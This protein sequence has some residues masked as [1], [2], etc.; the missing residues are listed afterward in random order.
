MDN[1][2]GLPTGSEDEA[3][4]STKPEKVS[5]PPAKTPKQ[6]KNITPSPRAKKVSPKSGQKLR[7]A[8]RLPTMNSEKSSKEMAHKCAVQAGKIKSVTP[9]KPALK[10][11]AKKKAAPKRKPSRVSQGKVSKG[12]PSKGKQGKPKASSS[13]KV[14]AETSKE[15]SPAARTKQ[16]L[17]KNLEKKRAAETE[18]PEQPPPARRVTAKSTDSSCAK[19]QP[20]EQQEDKKLARTMSSRVLQALQ[21][22]STRDQMEAA[23]KE[24][25]AKKAPVEEAEPTEEEKQAAEAAKRAKHNRK[26][27]FYRSLTSSLTN[28]ILSYYR[29]V[30]WRFLGDPKPALGTIS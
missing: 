23:A 21:R 17:E 24:P 13:K 6:A 12:K 19:D 22:A 28:I 7:R 11:S 4:P 20:P 27:R 14:P 26:N 15:P 3:T 18:H 30:L 16:L 25:Q 2:L 1:Q 29:M 5:E 8:T 9:K 10:A